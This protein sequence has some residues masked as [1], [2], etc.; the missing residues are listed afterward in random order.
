[1]KG[2]CKHCGSRASIIRTDPDPEGCALISYRCD[3][4][5]CAAEYQASLSYLGETRPPQAPQAH[6]QSSFFDYTPRG[7]QR[8]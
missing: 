1:M 3:N 7:C 8:S 5:K 2:R 4:P 6:I